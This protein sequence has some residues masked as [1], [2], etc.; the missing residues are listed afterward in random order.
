MAAETDIANP[1][2]LIADAAM[3][4]RT[5]RNW[6]DHIGS[7]MA[8]VGEGLCV[9]RVYLY[10]VHELEDGGLGQTCQ[11]DWAAPGLNRSTSDQRNIKERIIDDDPAVAGLVQASR[12]RGEMVEV[13]TRD[14]TGYLREDFEYQRSNRSCRS[15]SGSMAPGG[16]MSV[17]TTA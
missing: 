10:Q 13:H 1:A 15:Q 4:F 8:Q 9:S 11:A 2:F 6:R 7:I 12:R 14:L 3:R 5:T 16:D 17:S